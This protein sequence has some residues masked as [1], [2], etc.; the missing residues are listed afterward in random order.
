MGDRGRRPAGRL[1]LVGD[2]VGLRRVTGDRAEE[3]ADVGEL[4]EG[5][6]GGGGR[7][8]QDAALHELA[9][10]TQR[11]ERRGGTDDCV[12]V[13]VDQPADRRRTGGLVGDHRAHRSPEH[14][15]ALVDLDDRA[16]HRLEKWSTQ[17]RVG[18]GEQHAEPELTVLL[19][20][21]DEG[22]GGRR[23]G[24]LGGGVVA[25]GAGRDEQCTR[26]DAAEEVARPHVS[27]PARIIALTL[28]ERTCT[29]TA[30]SGSGAGRFGSLPGS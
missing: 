29:P 25:T 10:S 9:E 30:R 24:G 15:A 14:S 3:E 27:A 12:H 19:P 21:C 17:Q 22:R 20:W 13:G 16:P 2:D 7:A 18:G 23:G 8:G 6:G 4:V 28:G 1:G 11:D 26:E 5:E